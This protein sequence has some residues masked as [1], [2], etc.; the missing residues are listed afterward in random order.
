MSNAHTVLIVEDDET[1]RSTLSDKLIF[2]G[3]N[4]LTSKNGKEALAQA[5]QDKEIDI[6]LLDMMMPEM[7]G[8]EFTYVLKNTLQQDIPII[9]LTNLENITVPD[10][11]VKV[12]TKAETSLEE[13]VAEIKQILG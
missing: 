4:V 6:V 5:M 9:I 3:F 2:E 7:D 10:H 12:L 11:V 1:Y 8:V 13:I